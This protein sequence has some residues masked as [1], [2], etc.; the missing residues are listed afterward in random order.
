MKD[1]VHSWISLSSFHA[2]MKR[3]LGKSTK[4]A[5][6]HE[7]KGAAQQR[8]S[9]K[10]AFFAND[11]T[12]VDPISRFHAC[13]KRCLGKSTKGAP[14]H[15]Q[16]GA[17]QQR[18]SSK[19]AFFANDVTRVDPISRFHACMKRCLGKS[20]KGAPFHEQ[21]ELR[22]SEKAA[23]LHFLR[24]VWRGR[25]GQTSSGRK[26]LPPAKPADSSFSCFL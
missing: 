15:E 22:S 2:C 6:F 21:K 25:T 8:K 19:A 4:G 1:T 9:S 3:C 11:V 13:M 7:Q 20:T 14:F 12:R 16:K 10:A 26:K 17:A 18:K 24:M 23:K 5:P